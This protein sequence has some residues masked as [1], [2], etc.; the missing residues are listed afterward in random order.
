M[1]GSIC[2]VKLECQ[3]KGHRCQER[4][5]RLLGT[6]TA[7]L[8]WQGRRPNARQMYLLKSIHSRQGGTS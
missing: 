7:M 1:F 4:I 5:Y 6:L 8:N 2:A 3:L